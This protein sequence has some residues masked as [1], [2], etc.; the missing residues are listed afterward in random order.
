MKAYGFRRRLDADRQRDE[1][2]RIALLY[3]LDQARSRAEGA[4]ARATQAEQQLA[5]AVACLQRI[6]AD[7]AIVE[8]G[9]LA[10]VWLSEAGLLDKDTPT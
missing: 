3:Q 6:A 7:A 5:D 4:E 1:Q 8:G 9:G 10:W 2:D